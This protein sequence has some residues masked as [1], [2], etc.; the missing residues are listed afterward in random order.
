MNLYFISFHMVMTRLT[1]TE[2]AI[3]ARKSL[4]FIYFALLYEFE[5]LSLL[6]I[7]SVNFY[8]LG[9]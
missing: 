9:L 2:L 7:Q 1:I 6:S 5:Y 4:S 8:K 3:R